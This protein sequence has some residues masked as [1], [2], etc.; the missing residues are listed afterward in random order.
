[1]DSTVQRAPPKYMLQYDLWSTT[2]YA[3]YLDVCQGTKGAE[4]NRERPSGLP[5]QTQQKLLLS[6]ILTMWGSNM[7]LLILCNTIHAVHTPD[8]YEYTSE[9]KRI[10]LYKCRLSSTRRTI[11]K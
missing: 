8:E 3:K 5:K 4:A 1:M 6:M 9:Y 10:P 2:E 11:G 7:T